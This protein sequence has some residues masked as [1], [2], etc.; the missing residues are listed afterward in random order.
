MEL[1]PAMALLGAIVGLGE[2]AAGEE[3]IAMQA[4]VRLPGAHCLVGAENR[5]P[6]DACGYGHAGVRG[7]EVE[8]I[9]F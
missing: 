8:P 3:L 2:L 9:G 6:G 7:S 5:A 1:A 4:L